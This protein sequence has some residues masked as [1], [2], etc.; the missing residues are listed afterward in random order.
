MT[1]SQHTF[2]LFS[3]A[4]MALASVAHSDTLYLQDG[5]QHL[6]RLKSMTADSVV[7]EGRDGVKTW[8]K[9]EVSRIQLQRTRKYDDVE[10]VDQITDP[11]L[12]ACLEKQPTEQEYP[13]DGSVTLFARHTF[14]LTTPGVVKDTVRTITK[15]LR[16][17]GEDAGSNNAWYFEDTD[18][19]EID[20]ALTIT[21]DGRVLHLSDDAVKS[22]SIYAQ[23][24]MYRR[25]SRL[26]FA[27]KEPRPGSVL[28]VQYTVIRKRPGGLE[29]FYSEEFFRDEAPILR[30]EVVVVAPAGQ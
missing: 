12:K 25:L 21:P 20:F 23:L 15:I 10:T 19:P 16:Q 24:P 27:C 28:D 6:G 3:L 30:K 17:R 9:S 5:E 1:R 14:D 18:L 26:R 8:P 29:P 7:F 22:E 13:A 11:D 4:M 2:T